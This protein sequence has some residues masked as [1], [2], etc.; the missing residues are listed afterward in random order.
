MRIVVCIKQVPDNDKIETDPKTNSLVRKNSEKRLNR[1]DENAIE[2]AL[3]LK[4]TD[5]NNIEIIALTMG[6]PESEA[7][8][9][10]AMAME[11]TPRSEE[12]RVGKECRSRWSPYH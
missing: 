8:L 3:L 12:R 10:Q 2:Q 1:N 7:I 5:P 11:A 6:P 9:R 4:D